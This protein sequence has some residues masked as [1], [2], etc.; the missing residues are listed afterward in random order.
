VSSAR[1]E[2]SS[3]DGVG[4]VVGKERMRRYEVKRGRVWERAERT[5]LRHE[6]QL[7]LLRSSTRRIGRVHTL[8]PGG[9]DPLHWLRTSFWRVQ[10]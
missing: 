8:E 4:E 9:R 10:M 5:S 1:A 2:M 3:G 6:C 7:C